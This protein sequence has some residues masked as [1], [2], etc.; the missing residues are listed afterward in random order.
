MSPVQKSLGNA[1]ANTETNKAN[2]P[3]FSALYV[4]NLTWLTIHVP[5]FSTL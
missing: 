2:A 1:K 3:Y 5:L 4:T